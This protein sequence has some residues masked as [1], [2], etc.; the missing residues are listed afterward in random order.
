[1]ERPG[2]AR[3]KFER[4]MMNRRAT[5]DPPMSKQMMRHRQ[6]EIWMTS[7]LLIYNEWNYH[8]DGPKVWFG[9]TVKRGAPLKSYC[10]IPLSEKLQQCWKR[11]HFPTNWNWCR[12]SGYW[13]IGKL[14]SMRW[15]VRSRNRRS[16]RSYHQI[17]RTRTKLVFCPPCRMPPLNEMI[18]DKSQD[19]PGC[20]AT[21]R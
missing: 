3:R 10:Q 9:P 12:L 20:I 21:M 16:W 14:Q 13:G 15:Q 19:R 17:W 7:S 4:R 5:T 2:A 1:M 6:C 11:Q 8:V 18:E